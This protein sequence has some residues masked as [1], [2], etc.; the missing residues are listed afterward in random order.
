LFGTS[1]HLPEPTAC[2]SPDEPPPLDCPVCWR[3]PMSGT[4]GT[5]V[6]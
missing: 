2:T 4:D 1:R 5:T 3:A 6:P